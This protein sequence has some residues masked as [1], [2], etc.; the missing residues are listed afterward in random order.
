MTR[1]WIA[2]CIAVTCASAGAAAP[3]AGAQA[4]APP[5]LSIGVPD[6]T[7]VPPSSSL[8]CVAP[9]VTAQLSGPLNFGYTAP[10]Y[11]TITSWS[12]TISG[13]GTAALVT[14]RPAGAGTYAIATTSAP[15][16][17]G[18]IATQYAFAAGQA[19]QPGDVIGLQ[20]TGG[21]QAMTLTATDG[22][23]AAQGDAATQPFSLVASA[24][25]QILQVNA[26]ITRTPSIASVA[27]A[28]GPV[29]GGTAVAITGQNLDLTSAVLFGSTPATS[30]T[31]AGSTGITAI[32]PAGVAATIDVTVVGQGGASATSAADQFTFVGA[33]PAPPA[34]SAPSAPK[35][36]PCTVPALIGRTYAV[37][38]RRLSAAHCTVGTVT[39]RS[40]SPRRVVVR[41]SPIPGRSLAYHGKVSLTLGRKG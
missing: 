9:C 11:G 28:S 29:A 38:K 21:A 24:A 31:T 39:I 33:T 18:P 37:A 1:S 26:I 34:P 32:A 15:Q 23:T 5:T 36:P 7:G 8:A 22:S 27:P 35:R 10:V 14:L 12:A 19:V 6:G 4:P 16:A 20:T 2:A 25:S 41:Q 13:S 17:V 30:F 40:R 3:I